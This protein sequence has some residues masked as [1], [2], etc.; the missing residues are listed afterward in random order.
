[1][2]KKQENLDQNTSTLRNDNMEQ[3]DQASISICDS[4]VTS[5]ILSEATPLMESLYFGN[6]S[7]PACSNY[8]LAKYCRA[9]SC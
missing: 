2:G 7:V 9:I 3:A 5:A 6:R 4:S 1:M 8:S